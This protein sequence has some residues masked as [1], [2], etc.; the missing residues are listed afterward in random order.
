VVEPGEGCDPPDYLH[1]DETCQPI[2]CALSPSSCGNGVVE[3]G[4]AC[5]PP[6]AGSCDPDCQA[7]PCAAPA[8]GEID[9]ACVENGVFEVGVAA[10]GNATDY[11]I[12]W[13]GPF[14]RPT[15]DVLSRRF[16]TDGVP[17]DPGV[18]VVSEGAPCGS[19]HFEPSAGSDGDDHYVTW[20]AYGFLGPSG[21]PFNAILGRRLRADGSA[22]VID[23]HALAVPV[24]QC[25]STVTTP[26]ASA[27]MGSDRFVATWRNLSGCFNGPLLQNPAGAVLS[28]DADGLDSSVG[29]ALGFPFQPPPGA[30]SDSGAS[31]ASLAGETLAVWHAEAIPESQPP[32]TILPFVA[33]AWV[34]PSGMVSQAILTA[35]TRN[36][37]GRPAVSAGAASLLVAWAQ[38]GT[39]SATTVTEIRG[40]RATHADGRLDPDGGLLLATTAGGTVRGGPAV[41]FDGTVWLV[42]WTEETGSGNE[43]RAVAVQADG[44]VVDATPRLLATNVAAGDPAAASAGNGRVLVVFGRPD[45]G[46]RAVRAVLVPGT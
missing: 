15:H 46:A 13:T 5:E 36:F 27:G 38:G 37:A 44:T 17:S 7:A 11:L 31:V 12:A 8:L 10:A 21:P 28:F 26:T 33:A 19:G 16:D 34:E 14:R 1:C 30:Y 6:A 23:Q 18:R 43:L 42:A 4:E 45:T 39:D 2:T 24:G 22:D 35:R 29:F 20:G 40:V 32:F 9:V 41:A 25:S 3:A